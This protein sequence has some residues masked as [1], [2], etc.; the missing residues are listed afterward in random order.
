M[1]RLTS[2]L[3]GEVNQAFFG[4]GVATRMIVP[5]CPALDLG[6]GRGFSIEG[7]IN[8]ASNQ[9]AE[10]LTMPK[11]PF[12]PTATQ[13]GFGS[14]PGLMGLSGALNLFPRCGGEPSNR[15]TDWNYFGLT[16]PTTLEYSPSVAINTG[17]AYNN[18]N[19]RFDAGALIVAPADK[20]L[21]T[22]TPT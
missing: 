9:Q 17:G 16:P 21:T 3:S 15:T 2:G 18:T 20:T 19:V 11:P 5:R 8:P 4:D 13:M 10:R 12:L 6:R 7:W 14:M 22:A 1:S